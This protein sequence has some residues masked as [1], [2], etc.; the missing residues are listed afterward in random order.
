MVCI[1]WDAIPYQA[2]S[3]FS[4]A[5]ANPT[6]DNHDKDQLQPSSTLGIQDA[7]TYFSIAAPPKTSHLSL[8]AQAG[9]QEFDVETSSILSGQIGGELDTTSLG[10]KYPKYCVALYNY[11]VD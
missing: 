9:S 5:I 7:V 10:S 2:S 3:N 11:K 6:I 8:S 4:V 1:L